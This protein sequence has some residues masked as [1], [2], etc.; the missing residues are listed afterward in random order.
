MKYGKNIHTSYSKTTPRAEEDFPASSGNVGLSL[1][2]TAKS[3]LASPWSCFSKKPHFPKVKNVFH[4]YK[5]FN[6]I[7]SQILMKHFTQ[8][9]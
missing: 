1:D 4:L 7:L 3:R 2:Q 6:L 9:D 5:L 8:V